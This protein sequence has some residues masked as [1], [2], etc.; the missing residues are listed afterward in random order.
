MLELVPVDQDN[1]VAYRTAGTV[2]ATDFDLVADEIEKKLETQEELLLYAELESLQGIEPAA[3]AKDIA[4]GARHLDDLRRFARVAVV[5]DEG[6][7]ETAASAEGGLIPGLDIETF[8]SAEK[9]RA[10]A[11]LLSGSQG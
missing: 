1:V 6:W 3:L 4:F 5:T 10:M 2:T 9:E 11:W 7:I 8:S